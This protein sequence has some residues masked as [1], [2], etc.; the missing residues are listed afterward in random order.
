MPAY[1]AL[2]GVAF[3]MIGTHFRQHRMMSGEA[4]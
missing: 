1:K 4:K 3:M 2:E